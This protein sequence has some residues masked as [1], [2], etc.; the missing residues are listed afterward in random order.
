MFPQSVRGTVADAGG[1]P[2][3][4][5]LVQLIASDSSIAARALTGAKGEFL[6][7]AP[8]AGTYRVRTLRIGYRP[9][10]SDPFAIGAG[11]EVSRQFE[12]VGISLGLDTVRVGGRNACGGAADA[13]T[14]TLALWEQARAAITATAISGTDRAI[15]TR[16][17]L[18]DQLL[19][20]AGFR[21]LQ[22]SSTVFTLPLAQ[23]W[24]SESPENL[25]QFGYI[26]EV[27]DSTVYRAPGLEVLASPPFF[28]DHCFRLVGGRERAEIGIEFTPTPERRKLA[29]VRGTVWMLRA[30]AELRRIEFRYVNPENRDTETGARGEIDFVRMPNGAW[31]VARWNIRMPVL[32]VVPGA[33]V[34]GQPGAERLVRVAAIR[35]TGG[36]LA[37]VTAGADTLYSRPPLT[38][39][40]TV[41]DSG[42]GRSVAAAM[43][44]LAGTS[45]AATT[46]GRGRFSMPGVLPGTYFMQVRTPALDTLGMSS[47]MSVTVTDAKDQLSVRVPTAMQLVGAICGPA[48][49]ARGEIPG[50]VMGRVRAKDGDATP[51]GVKVVVEWND[52][53]TDAPRW[54]ETRAD[55]G[56]NFRICGVPLHRSLVLRASNDTA[57]AAPVAIAVG[58][59]RRME[60]VT[61]VL[62]RAGGSNAVFAGVVADSAGN[63]VLGA[64]ITLPDLDLSRITDGRGAFRVRDIPGGTHRVV[65][66]KV[67]Y[68]PVDTKLDFGPNETVERRVV[69]TRM[70]VLEEVRVTATIHD[71]LMTQFNENVKLGLGH[72]IT[73]DEMRKNEGR[74]LS[75]LLTLLPGIWVLDRGPSN[76]A[77][78]LS[79]RR[80]LGYDVDGTCIPCPMAVYMDD[81]LISRWEVPDIN[82]FSTRDIEAVEVYPGRAQAPPKYNGLREFC[83]VVVIHT[84][85]P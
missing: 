61:L 54:A 3:P 26:V 2:V 42:S 5:V 15:V 19:D 14:M 16:R 75:D 37:L 63:P 78:L 13:G 39:S 25:H 51:T 55:S 22:Q 6:I 62:D 77:V 50:I 4:G 85:R 9:V 56:G 70:T 69:L 49:A 31:G 57:S 64:E 43:V 80:C 52:V 34:R 40:G 20:G 58:D 44:A 45:L 79:S 59:E 36:E 17:V 53:A 74:K 73:P 76:R 83:G 35:A 12:L 60:R 10:L 81:F 28:G 30:G 72:F 21:T 71:R 66:R 84:R 68:G 11:Q 32:E 1:V 18:H 23:P 82:S 46:D 38:L 65:V 24:A 48:R 41:S 47:E 8:R 27:L 33:R 7:G 29:D 67:G